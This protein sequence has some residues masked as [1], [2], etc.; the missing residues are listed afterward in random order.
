MTVAAAPD[1]L[2]V[3]TAD[4]P[5]LLTLPFRTSDEF[6][7]IL[8][9]DRKNGILI[10]PGSGVS[11][12][13]HDIVLAAAARKRRL[14]LDADALTSFGGDPKELFDALAGVPCVLTPHEAPAA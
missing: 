14:V 13:T 8:E 4:Q 3:F 10:G 12:T 6:E 5:G 1:A 11:R 9:N 2:H 7:G